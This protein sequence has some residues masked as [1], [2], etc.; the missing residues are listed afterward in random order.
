[1]Y[2][3]VLCETTQIATN[4]YVNKKHVEYSPNGIIFSNKKEQITD[5]NY[6][7]NES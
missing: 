1:M 4:L 3:K 7:M 2:I 6:N 5:M